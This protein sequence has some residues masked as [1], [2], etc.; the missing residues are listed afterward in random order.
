LRLLLVTLF[1]ARLCAFIVRMNIVPFLPDLVRRYDIGYTE[2]GALLSGFLIGYAVFQIPAGL[3]ADRWGG[4]RALCVGGIW[5]AVGAAGFALADTYALAFGVRFFLGVGVSFLFIP[6]VKIVAATVPPRRR[7]RVIGLLEAAVGLSMLLTLSGFPVLARWVTLQFIWWLSFACFLPLVCLMLLVLRQDGGGQHRASGST[8]DPPG[9]SATPDAKA[10]APPAA[11]TT[12][13]DDGSWSGVPA[14]TPLD[15]RL[16]ARLAALAS[17][18]L[19][20]YTGFVSF[21]PSCLEEAHGWDKAVVGPTMSLFM[22]T[23]MPAA[24]LGGALS[25]RVGRRVPIMNLGTIIVILAFA[26]VIAS[27]APPAIVAAVALAGLGTPPMVNLIQALCGE[28]F[29]THR[30]GLAMS[31]I[32]TAGQAACALAGVLFGWLVDATGGFEAIWIIGVAVLAA[33]MLL[34]LGVPE[35]GR[36]GRRS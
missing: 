34:T 3:L 4:R 22:V 28:V 32:N 25:D 2:A 5:C 33:R 27:H 7:G 19:L 9:A 10:A 29:A 26:L 30:V 12:E 8:S 13:S 31:V 15:W 6:V 14:D 11:R 17:L 16:V 21:L 23:Q 20:A 36:A 35:G 1:I 18:A 24:M